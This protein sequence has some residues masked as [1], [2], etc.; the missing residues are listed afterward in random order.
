MSPERKRKFIAELAPTDD[1]HH[2]MIEVRF[3]DNPGRCLGT[4]KPVIA[5]IQHGTYAHP[6]V[7]TTAGRTEAWSVHVTAIDRYA[8]FA[9][10]YDTLE[11]AREVFDT[12]VARS[13][14]EASL[15]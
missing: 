1:R 13:G 10:S 3:L 12:Y 8:G 2:T 11:Q 5:W 9:S 6:G 7:S 4:T 15:F 14:Q